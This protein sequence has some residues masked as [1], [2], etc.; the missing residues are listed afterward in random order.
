MSRNPRTKIIGFYGAAK[1][2]L[3]Q[4]FP[5]F[6]Q[7]IHGYRCLDLLTARKAFR[8]GTVPAG[9][10]TGDKKRQTHG[11]LY[12]FLLVTL[13]IWDQGTT[14]ANESVNP[15]F[16]APVI[17]PNRSVFLNG[18]DISSARN[19]ELRN[20][21]VKISENGDLFISAP[22]YQ[23][24]ESETFMPLSPHSANKTAPIEH[25]PPQPLRENGS[26]SLPKAGGVGAGDSGNPATSKVD[27]A[28]SGGLNQPASPTKPRSGG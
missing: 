15:A 3:R 26:A 14:L 6:R 28:M 24:T 13:L 9:T 5:S 18:Q 12:A 22:Q 8:I 10:P 23:V 20:V 19:E 25:R 11:Y 16:K 4:G 2:A 27:P 21:H 7:T 1:H 17:T